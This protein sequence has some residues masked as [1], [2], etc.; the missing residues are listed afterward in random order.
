MKKRILMISPPGFSPVR[1]YRGE[2]VFLHLPKLDP[3]IE[4]IFPSHDEPWKDIL[5]ADIVYCFRTFDPKSQQVAAQAL[6][7]GKP[8]WF[9]LDDDVYRVRRSHPNYAG[10]SSQGLKNLVDW[11][12]RTSA[13]VTVSTPALAESLKFKRS[14]DFT[15]IPNA[16]DNYTLK[17][18]EPELE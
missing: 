13:V 12:L 15:V 18:L 11:F 8:I 10:L 14:G 7:M 17:M 3:E 2:G 6:D 4:I 5:S 16:I 9:D 1:A